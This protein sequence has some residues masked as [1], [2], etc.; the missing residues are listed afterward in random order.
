MIDDASFHS[1]YILMSTHYL[2]SCLK[3][4]AISSDGLS[5]YG[6]GSQY[7]IPS[8]QLSRKPRRFQDENLDNR[9]LSS[10]RSGHFWIQE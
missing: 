5:F 4:L 6:V 3:S 10:P 8:S 9:Q 1:C 2:L 7:D